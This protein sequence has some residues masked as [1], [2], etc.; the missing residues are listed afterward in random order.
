MGISSHPYLYSLSYISVSG[1]PGLLLSRYMCTG[2]KWGH[3]HLKINFR[4]IRFTSLALGS[5]V[6]VLR[7][8]LND[9]FLRKKNPRSREAANPGRAAGLMALK[10]DCAPNHRHKVQSQWLLAIIDWFPVEIY[11]FPVPYPFL[12][13]FGQEQLLGWSCNRN[14]CLLTM[15]Y[16]NPKVHGPQQNTTYFVV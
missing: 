13:M 8:N 16:A 12:L 15:W 1:S 10:S 9:K 2:F 11:Y 14:R 3:S 5:S 4:S 6:P 7:S